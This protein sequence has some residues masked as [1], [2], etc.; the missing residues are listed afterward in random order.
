MVRGILPL[1][2]RK[3]KANGLDLNNMEHICKNKENGREQVQDRD[4]VHRRK[5]RK[6]DTLNVLKERR[7][8]QIWK[9]AGYTEQE[10]MI[11]DLRAAL[12]YVLATFKRMT[13]FQPS[14]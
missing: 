14:K 3:N 6:Q 10:E 9:E 2:S 11:A 7:I 13:S 5:E 4:L 1:S 8:L 12:N